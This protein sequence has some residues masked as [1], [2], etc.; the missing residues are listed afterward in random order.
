MAE[1]PAARGK[2]KW[3][4][5]EKGFGFLVGEDGVDRFFNVQAVK[6]ADL[7]RNG[8]IVSFIAQEGK[9]GPRAGLVKILK[10]GADES[11]RGRVKCAS[12]GMAMVPRMITFR[13]SL[14]RSVCPFCGATYKNFGCFIA[15]AVYGAEAPQVVALRRFRDQRLIPHVLGRAFV[16]IYY[17]VSPP[18]ARLLA[19]LPK[20]A[21]AVRCG[22]DVVVAMLPPEATRS[23]A[24]TESQRH[25]ADAAT[26]R[27]G[28]EGIG[29]PQ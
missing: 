13:G 18:I 11:S 28:Q 3:F 26:C 9:K 6:G 2:I 12:C 4:S 21:A 19:N 16:A 10:R 24:S 5:E 17:R 1:P 25:T 14:D 15:T 20:V 22:L 8:D 23:P 27:T 7:P 29:G